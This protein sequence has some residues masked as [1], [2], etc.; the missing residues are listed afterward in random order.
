MR[1][2]DAAGFLAASLVITAFWMK[3]IIALRCIAL[4]SNIAF[5]IY[6]TGLGLLP[7]WALHAVLLPINASRLCQAFWCDR[8]GP[9]ALQ[10][11][12]Q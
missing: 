9:P 7:V 6:G 1:L 12:R 5:L 3:D 2:Y 8:C 11:D 4:A 10:S